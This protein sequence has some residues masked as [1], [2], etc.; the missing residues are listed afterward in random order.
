MQSNQNVK[1]KVSVKQLIMIFVVMNISPAV[2]FLPVFAAKSANEAGWI[3]PIAAMPPVCLLIYLLHKIFNKYKEQNT[4]EVIKDILGKYIGTALL[5]VHF[6]WFFFL[7]S[8]FARYN[9][10]RLVSSIYTNVNL[11]FFIIISLIV[12]SY[13][14][15]SGATAIARMGEILFPIIFI[16]LAFLLAL[17]LPRIRI[18]TIF[19]ISFNDTMP[20]IKASVGSLS[21]Y[22]SLFSLFL[23]SDNIVG[24]E[25]IGKLYFKGSLVLLIIF[26]ALLLCSFGILGSSVVA[27]S[28][29][30]FLSVVKQISIFDTI[31]NIESIVIAEWM[32]TDALLIATMSILTLNIAKNLFKLSDTRNNINIMFVL[33][34]IAA[35]S[36]YKNRLELDLFA[37]SIVAPFSA[38]FG[39]GTPVLL[40]IVGKL[41]KKL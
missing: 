6:F 12:I 22:A 19:P 36:F 23:F 38:L 9:A 30:P 24:K 34:F 25:N 4:S 21:L 18:D 7:T 39:F 3:S 5:T 14:L 27:R 8:F 10:E 15:R 11:N 37:F 33:A 1:N 35:N 20:I 40:F 26:I 41:R 2:R 28:P 29:I 32:L 16:I 17:L 31:E 13:I